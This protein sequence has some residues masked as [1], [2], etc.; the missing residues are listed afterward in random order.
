MDLCA[1]ALPL[2]FRK[3]DN[4]LYKHPIV[5]LNLLTA[6][7]YRDFSERT[8]STVC[9]AVLFEKHLIIAHAGD[10]RG[11]LVRDGSIHYESTD[12]TPDSPNEKARINKSCI[13][14]T[15]YGAIVEVFPGT[16]SYH[17]TVS[18]GL[19]DFVY[20]K[21]PT[22]AHS[23][24]P[25]LCE[26]D[27]EVIERHETDEFCVVGTDG[28]WSCMSSEEV[29]NFVRERLIIGGQSC[30]TCLAQLLERCFVDNGSRDNISIILLKF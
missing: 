27:V 1:A 14:T 29:M 28:L 26:P 10:S 19:G 3:T 6:G 7:A 11:I 9:V 4:W 8:G 30:E 17:L 21:D 25:V 15:Q 12:H 16:R 22:V 20:K 23:D 2:G 24:Q 5:R 13:A 18:R